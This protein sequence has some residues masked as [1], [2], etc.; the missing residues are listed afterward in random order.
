MKILLSAALG[1]VILGT[2]SGQSAPSESPTN[3]KL[4]LEG[5]RS[6]WA[7]VSTGADLGYS[8]GGWHFS[9][10]GG[11]EALDFNRV[12][13]T[14]DPADG[15]PVKWTYPNGTLGV[16]YTWSLAEADL[17]AGAG[18]TGYGDFGLGTQASGEFQDWNG[19][20]FAL[21]KAGVTRDR[22]EYNAH[23]LES[24]TFAEASA[25]WSPAALSVRGTDFYRLNLRTAAFV[26]L[27]DLEAPAQLFSALMAFR[28]NLQWTDGTSV[29]LPLLTAT[30]VR[31]YSH[32]YDAKFLG[33]G[34]AELRGRLWS[35]VGVHDLVPVGFFFVDAGRYAGY[36]DAATASD[37]SGW[38]AGAGM[39]GGLEMFG[40][41]TPTLTLG[42][43]LVNGD[44]SLYWAL[45]FNLRF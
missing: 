21:V 19:N 7:V 26:P 38:L 45:D 42:L 9:V 16:K 20:L 6:N 28:A 36:A 43:P 8:V 4:D 35:W 39:G 44:T 13:G 17:W 2:V 40:A 5:V 15:A 18:A 22:R 41:A 29:P 12:Q 37:R 11:Y 25:V 31:G 10:G 32:L 27:W 1:L 24:G 34:T 3:G 33:V 14:G 23:N 30:E